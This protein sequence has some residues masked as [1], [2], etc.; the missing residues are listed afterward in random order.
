MGY[1]QNKVKLMMELLFCMSSEQRL[2]LYEKS[3][4]HTETGSVL[5][6]SHEALLSISPTQVSR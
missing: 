4:V 1:E 3:A 2:G 6:H 5:A